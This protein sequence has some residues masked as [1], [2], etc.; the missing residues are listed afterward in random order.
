MMLDHSDYDLTLYFH[1]EAL[2]PSPGKQFHDD[3]LSYSLRQ[4]IDTITSLYVKGFFPKG[5]IVWINGDM[6]NAGMWALT[7]KSSHIRTYTT[8]R[9]GWCRITRTNVRFGPTSRDT[10]SRAAKVFDLTAHDM[11]EVPHSTILVNYVA[12]DTPLQFQ[13]DSNVKKS[14]NGVV[15]WEPFT[16][17]DLP[18]HKANDRVTGNRLELAD[19]H[20]RGFELMTLGCSDER[21]EFAHAN[22]DTFRLGLKDK[23]LRG[24]SDESSKTNRAVDILINK[25]SD[26]MH[27]RIIETGIEFNYDEGDEPHAQ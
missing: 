17:I 2:R 13:V 7:D 14:V 12:K 15:E 5:S 4:S 6:P 26:G 10:G 18:R 20:Q 27:Q 3:V 22:Y 25:I 21:T 1:S 16:V 9:P 19:A 8:P 11:L 24:I 23:L